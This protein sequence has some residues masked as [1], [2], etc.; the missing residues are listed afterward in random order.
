MAKRKTKIKTRGYNSISILC[1]CAMIIY[2]SLAYL[3]TDK[4]IHSVEGISAEYL[5][6]S[7]GLIFSLGAVL[8]CSSK[9]SNDMDKIK[10]IFGC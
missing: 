4:A 9:Y 2:F 3:M 7:F 5:I 1:V 8:F 6:N 10:K